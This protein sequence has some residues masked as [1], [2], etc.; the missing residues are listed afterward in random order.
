MYKLHFPKTWEIS[1]FINVYNGNQS[2]KFH[3][4]INQN[5]RLR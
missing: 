3:N 5:K 4:V 2:S 1:T